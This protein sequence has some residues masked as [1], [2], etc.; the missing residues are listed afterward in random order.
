M[1]S[2]QGARND[3]EAFLAHY[4][5]DARAAEVRHLD[6]AVKL[7]TA[8]RRASFRA[9][10]P[11][12]AE[13]ASPIERAYLDAVSYSKLNPETAAE[14][15]AALVDLYGGDASLSGEDAE[16]IK[17]ARWQLQQLRDQIREQA[18]AELRLINARLDKADSLDHNDPAAARAMREAVVK[19][20]R[21]KPWAAAAVERADAALAARTAAGSHTGP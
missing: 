21:D 13:A 8:S 19:L 18:D 20:Y 14:R 2:L 6:D 15:L 1:A 3:I 11:I 5:D 7:D 17:L 4:S 12:R 16:S 9:R 10:S